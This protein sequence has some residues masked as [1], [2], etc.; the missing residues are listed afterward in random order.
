[1]LLIVHLLIGYRR[2]SALRYY[3]V[4]P[5]L[6]R[7]LGLKRLRDVA[8]VSRTLDG[9]DKTAVKHLH[10]LWDKPQ[11]VIVHTRERGS[12]GSRCSSVSSPLT[13]TAAGSRSS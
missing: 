1:M 13:S 2:L 4:D 8:T 11:R 9:I 3:Q 10:G 7:T 5:M 12:V 6:R